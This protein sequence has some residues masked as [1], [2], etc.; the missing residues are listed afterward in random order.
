MKRIFTSAACVAV[1]VASPAIAGDFRSLSQSCEE[2]L[3]LSAIPSELRERASVYVWQGERFE[4]TISSDGGIHCLVERNHPESIIPQCVTEAGEETILPGLMYRTGKFAEGLAPNEVVQIMNEQF[5]SGALAAP[6]APG[7]NY[8]LSPFNRIYV[9]Q[10]D[11]IVH[12]APHTMIFAPN[13]TNESVGGIP[14]RA[15][16]RPGYP[17]VLE[18]GPHGYIVTFTEHGAEPDDVLSACREQAN[19]EVWSADTD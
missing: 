14:Q 16:T 19:I 13:A 1:L 18:S 11:R 9:Q 3:A 10:A 6:Q 17:M 2:A 5:E 12:V 15:Q 8:M 7:I 4:K